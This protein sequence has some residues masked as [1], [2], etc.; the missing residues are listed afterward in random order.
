MKKN[1]LE[2]FNNYRYYYQVGKLEAALLDL[3]CKYVASGSS[4][5]VYMVS[6]TRVAK[7]AYS[8]AG[9]RQNEAEYN[10]YS[11]KYSDVLAKTYKPFNNYKVIISE[12]VKPLSEYRF[13]KI[14]G[15]EFYDFATIFFREEHHSKEF[16]NSGKFRKNMVKFITKFLSFC[17]T[18]DLYGFLEFTD[19][20]Q[21]GLSGDK[22]KLLDYGLNR[23]VYRRYYEKSC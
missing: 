6:P 23:K 4:R 1:L 16:I 7:I 11:K 12:Y 2:L 22:L 14:Y 15:L 3:G 18:V 13:R 8:A 17:N 21:W 5:H 9:M 10:A 19:T 20:K